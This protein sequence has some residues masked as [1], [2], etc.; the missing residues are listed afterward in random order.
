MSHVQVIQ[1]IKNVVVIPNGVFIAKVNN[2]SPNTVCARRRQVLLPDYKIYKLF[3]FLKTIFFEISV[4]RSN[5]F[6][7]MVRL[8]N[9]QRN[10]WQW[11]SYQNKNL[12]KWLFNGHCIWFDGNTG[13]WWWIVPPNYLIFPESSCPS[14][15]KYAY[16]HGEYCCRTNKEKIAIERDGDLCDGSEIGIDS[17][18]CENDDWKLCGNRPCIN[19]KDAFKKDQGKVE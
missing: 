19:H 8:V 15:H 6:H 7:R 3:F 2:S 9:L 11:D 16:R 12:W 14:S 5:S 13:L 10:L 18:C 17:L 4:L 1:P